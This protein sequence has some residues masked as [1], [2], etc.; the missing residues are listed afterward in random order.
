MSDRTVLTELVNTVRSIAGA[1]DDTPT[2]ALL[3][4]AADAVDEYIKVVPDRWA[5]PEDDPELERLLAEEE[6]IERRAK[7]RKAEIE[8]EAKRKHYST[9]IP[10]CNCQLC[11]W[12]D[13]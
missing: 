5:E 11:L 12:Q 2:G 13:A 8:G 1:T 3:N 7:E 4:L 10:P 9:P 6:E